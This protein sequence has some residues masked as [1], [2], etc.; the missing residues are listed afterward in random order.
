MSQEGQNP[1]SHP[2]PASPRGDIRRI[3]PGQKN[4]PFNKFEDCRDLRLFLQP[5]ETKHHHE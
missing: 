2:S 5:N 4:G 3:N 1:R